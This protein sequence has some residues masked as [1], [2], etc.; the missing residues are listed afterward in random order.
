M[1]RIIALFALI[2][3]VIG[4]GYVF[5]HRSST[6]ASVTVSP[7]ATLVSSPT[8]VSKIDY[9]GVD[10]KTA[11]ELLKQGHTVEIKT[12]SFG[13]LVTAIDGVSNAGKTNWTFYVNNTLASESASTYVTK[14]TDMIEWR[15]ELGNY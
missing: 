8:P 7:T 12:Y 1:K 5:K 4:G 3:I 11:L 6:A 9:K 13:D 2:I 14:S 15:Y 10:G